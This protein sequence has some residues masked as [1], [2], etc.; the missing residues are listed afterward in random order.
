MSKYGQ[1]N[2]NAIFLQSIAIFTQYFLQS[3]LVFYKIK[4]KYL[5][6]KINKTNII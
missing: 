1:N 3:K 5:H 6:K 4:I 2:S